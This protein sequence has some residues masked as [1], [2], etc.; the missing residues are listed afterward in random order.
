MAK[1]IRIE[2]IGDAKGFNSA[3]DE[4]D[5]KVGGL[6]RTMGGL[7]TAIGGAFAV[8]AVVTFGTELFNL[9]SDLELTNRKISTVFGDQA[10]EIE[11]WADTVN[12]SFGTSTTQVANMAAGV[13]DLIKPMG[14]T[15]EEA[16][17]M[18]QEIVGLAPALAQWSAGQYDAAEVSDILA[19]AMLGERDQLKGLGISISQA[20]VDQRALQLAH[21]DGRDA[22]TQMD[23]ALATQQLIFEKSTDAQAGFTAGTETLSGQQANLQA[24]MT[25]LKEYLATKL[26]PVFLAVGSWITDTAVP[27]VQSWIAKVQEFRPTL[28]DWAAKIESVSEKL[29]P[30]ADW[31]SQIAEWVSEND[32]VMTG[33]KYTLIGL[34]VA[35]A[36]VAAALAIGFGVAISILG[37]TALAIGTVIGVFSKLISTIK[38]N[39]TNVY[40]AVVGPFRDGINWVKDQWDS[41][42]RKVS[43]PFNIP[44]PFGG[45]S[46]ILPGR[47]YGGTVSTAGMYRINERSTVGGES[48]FLPAGARVAPSYAGA[49][50]KGDTFNIYAPNA[51]PAEVAREI[52]WRRRLGDGR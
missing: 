28:E 44:N 19:S 22:V 36:G 50:G 11:D 31:M 29:Q 15:T 35:V 26:T 43:E 8:D 52:A 24:K 4:V 5:G 13:A 42:K 45:L 41:L 38:D 9:S 16:A 49:E 40:N 1:P 30:L 27:A 37:A 48:V 33:L 10:D 25:E 3:A 20:E 39:S 51:T 18:S 6:Q 7:A 23:E 17:A 21:E 46:G 2:I 32:T 47:A 12:E 14:A 34:G